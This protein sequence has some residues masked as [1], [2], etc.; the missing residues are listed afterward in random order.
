MSLKVH[1]EYMYLAV[2]GTQMWRCLNPDKYKRRMQIDYA[3]KKWKYNND[4]EY[5][6]K[7]SKYTSDYRKKRYKQDL[8]FKKKLLDRSKKYYNSNKG[9]STL[10]KWNVKYRAENELSLWLYSN[11]RGLA[12]KDG[13]W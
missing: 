7:I 10:A 13:L 4:I 12:K 5:K 9:K 6:R 8:D 2:L 1:K 11:L 3:L